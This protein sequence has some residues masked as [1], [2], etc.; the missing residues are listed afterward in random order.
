MGDAEA[1][2]CPTK[3]IAQV[4]K[5]FFPTPTRRAAWQSS[6]QSSSQPSSQSSSQSSPSKT[7][8]PAST[9]APSRCES[10]CAEQPELVDVG[11][12]AVPQ[13][14]GLDDFLSKCGRHVANE[15]TAD[16]FINVLG[17]FNEIHELFEL[18]ASKEQCTHYLGKVLK[19]MHLKKVWE[20]IE[21]ERSRLGLDLRCSSLATGVAATVGESAQRAEASDAGHGLDI[22]FSRVVD[23]EKVVDEEAVEKE[24]VGCVGPKVVPQANRPPDKR[25]W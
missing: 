24:G 4:K 19:P 16:D 23:A 9:R 2:S 13:I 15:Y 18:I 11:M 7:A 10:E 8:S 22:A 14:V 21:L 25:A 3:R 5:A 1:P 12:Q 6:S 20:Q 17:G